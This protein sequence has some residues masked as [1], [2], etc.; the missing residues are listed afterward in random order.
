MICF[1]GA[2]RVLRLKIF[3]NISPRFIAALSGLLLCFSLSGCG[4]LSF[5]PSQEIETGHVKKATVVKTACSQIGRKYKAGE[6]SPHKGFDC[7][8][9]VWWSY[10]QHGINVPRITKD[11]ARAGHAVAKKNVRAGDIMVFKTSNSPNGLHTG[12]YCGKGAFVHSPGTG[13]KVCMQKL[14]GSWWGQ[15]LVAIR[16]V[17][18]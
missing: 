17:T 7:S 15:H 18:P 5:S 4:F 12:I 14:A 2:T 6:A 9:L 1:N 13:K 8:G 10:R 3:L 11:Q 16:R